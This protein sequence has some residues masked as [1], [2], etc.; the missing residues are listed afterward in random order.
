MVFTIFGC[1]FWLA[2]LKSIINSENPSSNPLV[3]AFWKPLVDQT[4]FL[5]PPCDVEN[6]SGSQLYVLWRKKTNTA[7]E[8]QN[9]NADAA[10]GTILIIN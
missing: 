6:C 8:S 3:L 5:N 1:F 7:K 10:F 2:S 9:R 4:L